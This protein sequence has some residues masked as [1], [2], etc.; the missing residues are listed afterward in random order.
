MQV[1]VTGGAGFLGSHLCETLLN[2]GHSVICVDN[3][4]TGSLH[5]IEHLR[6]N[7]NFEFIDFD[8]SNPLPENLDAQQIY[9]FA[10]PASPH[11]HNPK[12]YHALA[13]ETM[14]VNS[15][16][17]WNLCEFALKRNARIL[18]AST[19]ESYGDPLEH[20]QKETYNGNVSTTGPRSVYDE[21]K[22]FGET[23]VAAF[24]RKKGLDTRIIR[25]FNTYGPG[26]APND[27]RVVT[28]FLM[29]AARNEPIPIFG[30]GKQ[31]RSFMYVDDLISG[32]MKVMNSEKA[33][34]AEI[35][36]LGNPNEF[37]ILELAELV[38]NITGSK[39]EIKFAEPLPEND[40]LKRCPDITKAREILGWEPR[41]TLEDGLRKFINHL[42]SVNASSTTGNITSSHA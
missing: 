16:G 40:P 31:T 12:S 28:E 11:L 39:S 33:A 1:I 6:S 4:L 10:S 38:I 7:P 36:N 18:F 35:F 26:M 21:A 2:K 30:D 32:V 20:P 17:T 3:L 13:F 14:L 24:A 5:N 27:G 34:N 8:V 19:S 22:R 25:I 9:H 41:I 29:A 42:R 23:I 15:R 37:T